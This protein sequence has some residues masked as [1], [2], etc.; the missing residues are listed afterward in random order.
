MVGPFEFLSRLGL[1]SGAGPQRF[2]AGPIA[3][4]LHHRKCA[5]EPQAQH[6][7]CRYLDLHPPAPRLL[8]SHDGLYNVAPT[9]TGT[10]SMNA[11]GSY[12]GMGLS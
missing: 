1:G 11:F 10:R 4:K 12:H 5:C 6:Y 8:D 7:Q 3:G 2:A 9:T